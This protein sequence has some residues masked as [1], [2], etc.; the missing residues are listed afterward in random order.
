MNK[1][2]KSNTTMR[3]GVLMSILNQAALTL[4]LWIGDIGQDAPPLCGNIPPEKS[5]ICKPGD[6]VA[7]KVKNVST[8]DPDTS[9]SS[10]SSTPEDNEDEEN[11]ILAKIVSYNPIT[12]K[13]DIDDIDADEGQE[14]YTLSKKR[15]LPLPLWRANPIT[16][17]DAIFAKDSMVLA[18][19][20]QTTCFY[21]GIVSESPTT[22][23]EDY[24]IMFE[25]LTYPE[26]YSPPLNVPQLYV[27]AM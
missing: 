1:N 16:D 9:M 13:Y 14:R 3:R 12:K 10:A 6:K 25:D 5:Y 20:P 27:V 4:P 19:Y 18:L 23:H 22:P 11:W 8:D 17:A 2:R 7:A 24:L 21:R 15:I 26:G